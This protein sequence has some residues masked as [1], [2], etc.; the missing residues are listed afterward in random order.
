M[1]ATP[2]FILPPNAD[3]IISAELDFGRATADIRIATYTSDGTLFRIE[4]RTV[5]IPPAIRAT[6]ATLIDLKP[7]KTAVDCDAAI[8]ILPKT[9]AEES[10]E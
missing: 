10:K 2:I 1:I 9:A 7:P 5:T 4:S 6:I 3:S 8:A